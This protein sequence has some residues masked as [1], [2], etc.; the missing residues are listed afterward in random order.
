MVARFITILEA[1][2]DRTFDTQ[3][4]ADVALLK[5]VADAFIAAYYSPGE[6]DP[7]PEELT[8]GERAAVTIKAVR[9]YMRDVVLG[10]E[11][12]AAA[13]AA[14]NAVVADPPDLGVNSL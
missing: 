6:G 10:V 1:L 13:A 9:Q 12:N 11:A 14:R 2:L 3:D 7:L 5:R 4:P 8:N